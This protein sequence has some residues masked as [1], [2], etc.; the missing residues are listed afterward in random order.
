MEPVEKTFAKAYPNLAN[1]VE[2]KKSKFENTHLPAFIQDIV[3][4]ADEVSKSAEYNTMIEVQKQLA[5]LKGVEDNDEKKEINR[6]IDELKQK[7]DNTVA[8]KARSLLLRLKEFFS[9]FLIS[10]REEKLETAKPFYVCDSYVKDLEAFNKTSPD[11]AVGKLITTLRNTREISKKLLTIEHVT[12]DLAEAPKAHYIKEETT[13]IAN[14]IVSQLQKE[15]KVILQGGTSAHAVI[16]VLQ[17][18]ADGT[19]TVDV[20]NTGD[21]VPTLFYDANPKIFKQ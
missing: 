4:E 7:I 2:N 14:D 8:D 16:Y 18:E 6:V 5:K 9:K 10:Y 20:I 19:Y 11:P 17:K 13:T 21:G 12:K 3:Q 15:E 1:K